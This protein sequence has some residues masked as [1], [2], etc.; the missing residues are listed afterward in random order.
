MLGEDEEDER[1]PES[2]FRRLAAN[3]MVKIDSGIDHCIRN[4]RILS[5]G[6]S[7]APMHPSVR[8]YNTA[9]PH[10]SATP[11][12]AVWDISCPPYS[13]STLQ[14]SKST[15]TT[16]ITNAPTRCKASSTPKRAT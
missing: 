8:P 14:N 6:V 10:S 2:R 1:F 12:L 4:R 11:S 13:R 7:E 15:K 16:P 9:N 5:P 3:Q